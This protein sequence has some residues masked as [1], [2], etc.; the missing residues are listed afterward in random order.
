MSTLT[1]GYRSCENY[2]LPVL[3]VFSFAVLEYQRSQLFDRDV[4]FAAAPDVF[5][6]DRLNA[7]VMVLKPSASVLEDMLSKVSELPSH[8]GGDTG[9]LGLYD[10]RCRHHCRRGCLLVACLTI[11]NTRRLPTRATEQDS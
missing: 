2:T 8:D 3:A 9:E 4:D 7:G 5:P 10:E 11:S 1:L 6:P